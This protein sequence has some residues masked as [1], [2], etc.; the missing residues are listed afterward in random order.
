[1]SEK[2][3]TAEI[4]STDDEKKLLSTLGLCRRA[5]ALVLGTPMICDSLSKGSSK[6]VILVLEASD[7]SANTHKRI[8]DKCRFYGVRHHRLSSSG[9]T[10]AHAV[11]KSGAL[12]A[13]ALTDT[14]LRHAVE[15]LLPDLTETPT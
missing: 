11:G 14:Q 9:D 2:K 12:G 1:M 3:I 10:L 13:V 15:K 7:T 8:T 6:K 4:E 5:G